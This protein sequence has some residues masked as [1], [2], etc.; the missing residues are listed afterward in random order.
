VSSK[1]PKKKSSSTPLIVGV[2][3]AVVAA[4]A[5]LFFS[6][7]AKAAPGGDEGGDINVGPGG[8]L[9]KDGGGAAPETQ[10]PKKKTDAPALADGYEATLERLGDIAR[11][12]AGEFNR[13]VQD[14]MN[15][16]PEFQGPPPIPTRAEIL[17]ARRKFDIPSDMLTRTWIANAAYAAEFPDILI[18]AAEN[19]GSGWQPH[20]DLWVELSNI[21]NRNILK[22]PA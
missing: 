20:I 22:A 10:R 12:W 2:G 3:A 8:E 7:K 19:R 11:G 14:A 15:L 18:P 16:E 13:A 1:K 6:G 21:A 4:G 5:V 9:P 17:A